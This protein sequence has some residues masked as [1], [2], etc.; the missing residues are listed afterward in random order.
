M[1]K[2][3]QKELLAVVVSLGYDTSNVTDMHEFMRCKHTKL[4]KSEPEYRAF[5]DKHTKFLPKSA[6][7]IL[8]WYYIRDGVTK[9]KLCP[10]CRSVIVSGYDDKYCSH[11]CS[12]TV[13]TGAKRGPKV[14]L[15]AKEKS[16]R[17]SLDS[18]Y[19]LVSYGRH[20]SV[21]KH[22]CGTVFELGNR[23]LLNGTGGCPCQHKKLTKHTIAT[24][25]AWHAE[26]STGYRPVKLHGAD[27]TFVGEC[28]HRFRARKFYDRRC[29]KCFPGDSIFATTSLTHD[30]YTAKLAKRR[31]E[32]TLIG[33]Y[34]DGS[35]RVRYR[36]EKCGHTFVKTPNEV[37]RKLFRC[38]AC[39]PKTCGSYRVLKVGRRVIRVRGKENIALDWITKNTNITL[40]DIEVDS[41]GTVPSIR[42]RA[43]KRTQGYRPD[44][45]VRERNLLIEVKDGR[46]LGLGTVFF[47]KTGA[48]LWATNCAK[49]K[50]CL[51]QGYKFQMLLFNRSN[52]RVALPKN[53]FNLTHAQILKWAKAHDF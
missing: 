40:N 53:W 19:K 38:P 52:D 26:R 9:P 46:T 25:V 13:S 22:R 20:R 24:L 31:P 28:G 8:R 3:T 37:Q 17:K 10:V 33:R 50:A 1:N 44:F 11:G 4:Y 5:V 39:S 2:T 51:E 27:A 15:G 14:D 43:L 29:P 23:A 7:E 30:E 47:Y 21:F 6:P 32:L 42:F 36:H 12:T 41:D 49:A 45:Y 48:E 34:V 18:Q 16:L 35:T